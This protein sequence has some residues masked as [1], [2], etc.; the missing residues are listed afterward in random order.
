MA[1]LHGWAGL[2][3]GWLA[4][5]IFLFGTMAIFQEEISTWMRPELRAAA[6][7]AQAIDAADAMLRTRAPDAARWDISLPSPRSGDPVAISWKGREGSRLAG[8][9]TLDPATGRE[10][11]VRD[12]RGGY[13]LYRL[14]FDL[15]FM[16]A[17]W[18]ERIV[19]AA[20]LAMLV[21]ILS[22]VVTHKRIFADFFRLRI[23]R[24]QRSWLD[25]HH[26]AAVV[27]LPFY[28]M[29]TYTGLVALLFAAMPWAIAAHFPDRAAFYAAAD[30]GE[31][32][33]ETS[34]RPARPL[35]LRSL[36]ARAAAVSN[37]IAPF[38]LRVTNP[39]D[40]SSVVAAWPR[41]DALGD[42][43]GPIYLDAVTGA[44]L[45]GS[46]GHGGA[47]AAQGTMIALHTGLFAGTMLRWLYFLSGVGGT[48]MI[49][50][51]LILWSVKRRTRLPLSGAPHRGTA[52]VERLNVGVMVGAL[53]GTAIYF[54]SNRLLPPSFAQRAD[55][56]IN[57]LFIGW[58]A[59][60]VWTIAR[61]PRRAWIDGLA[62]CALLY[63]LVPAT[64]ALT[65]SRGLPQSLATRDWLFAGFDLVMI[66]VAVA[67]LS[68]ARLVAARR[69]TL[70]ATP[71][72]A[73]AKWARLA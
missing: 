5:V 64:N 4:F 17:L 24:G 6:A 18:A 36:T 41:H 71:A 56:E 25:A 63:A 68:A 73:R 49:A 12:T 58:G 48:A 21:A 9:A 53:A 55:W 51:G 11:V 28:L 57:G 72:R 29:M 60:L 13:F 27:A 43:H 39:G 16:P 59:L 70:S 52:L 46:Q 44:P 47:R 61:A 19:C 65:T 1:V 66:T 62:V 38:H 67:C 69:P 10:I 23:G 7:S 50:T 34:G 14:H 26:V 31:P 30:P 33:R 54:L 8:G 32:P 22:G 42:R 35:A 20:A 40:N 15:Y 37:G 45:P 2:L 3:A